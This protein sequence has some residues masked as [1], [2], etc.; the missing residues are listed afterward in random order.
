MEYLSESKKDVGSTSSLMHTPAYP[1]RSSSLWI[2]SIGHSFFHDSIKAYE[3]QELQ[4][5]FWSR[6][7]WS[8][9]LA[10]LVTCF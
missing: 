9:S 6:A 7:P 8:L 4:G 1:T 3:R 2:V 10:Q 5:A